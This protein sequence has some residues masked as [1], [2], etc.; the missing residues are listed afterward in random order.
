MLKPL[1]TTEIVQCCQSTPPVFGTFHGSRVVK[2]RNIAIKFG[3]GVVLSEHLNQAHAYQHVDKRILRVPQP[4]QFFRAE[5]QGMM[6]G[7]LVMEFL[8][9]DTLDQVD[10]IENPEVVARVAKAITHLAKIPLPQQQGP[11]PVGLSPARGYLWSDDGSG[12]PFT[13]LQDAELWMNKRLNAIGF[14][15]ISFARQALTMRHMDL[16]RRNILLLPNSSIGLLDWE[17]AGYYPQLFEIWTFR[18]LLHKD[19][20]WF[21]LLLKFFDTPS[22]ED[23]EKLEYMGIPAAVNLQYSYVHQCSVSGIGLSSQHHRFP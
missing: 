13:S 23:E 1:S 5:I 12:K 11:G 16:V 2:E 7:F 15:S 14:P 21:M 10:L 4:L 3:I 9:G 19:E 20:Q 6:M 17:Y 8:Q 18:H 22:S